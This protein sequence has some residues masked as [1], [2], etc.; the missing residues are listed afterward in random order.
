MEHG[1]LLET[2]NKRLVGCKWINTLNIS[3]VASWIDIKQD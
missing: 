3:L 2:E 1:R